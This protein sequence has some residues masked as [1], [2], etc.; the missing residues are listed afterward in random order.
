MLRWLCLATVLLAAAPPTLAQVVRQP[1]VLRRAP[2]LVPDAE[3]A[4]PF[5]AIKADAVAL[6]AAK[7]APAD[8]D[9]LLAY[10]ERRTLSDVD[11][12]AIQAVIDRLGAESFGDRLKAMD[13]AEKYGP[14]AVGP[15]RK[16]TA[17]DPTNVNAANFELAYRAG[18]VLKRLEKVPHAGIAIAAVRALA[19][20]PHP[21]TSRVL[22]GFLPQADDQATAEEIQRTLVVVASVGGKADA[23]L[24]ESLKDRSTLKR[25]YAATALIEGGDAKLRVRLPDAYPKVVEAARAE[26]DPDAKFVMTLALA[27]T[28]R[29]KEAVGA[30]L[31]MLPEL[32]RGRL[33]Q[34]EDLLLVLAGADAPKVAFGATKPAVVAAQAAWQAWWAKASPTLDLDKVTYAPRVQGKTLLVVMDP[35]NGSGYVAELGPDLK[36]RWR[37]TNLSSPHDA[38]VLPDGTVAVAE[39]NISSVSVRDTAGRLLTQKAITGNAA[40][41]IYGPPHQLQV[42]PGGDFVVVCRNVVVELKRD[43]PDQPVVFDRSNNHDIIAATRLPDGETA[44]LLL[45]ATDRDHLIVLD[46]A[47]KELPDRK[48]KTG[49]LPYQG[50]MVT[51]GEN[52]VLLTEQQKVVEYDLKE[53]KAVWSHAVMSARSVQRLPNGN[54]LMVEGNNSGEG[55]NRVI[56]VTPA[57]EEV[58]THRLPGGLMVVRAYRR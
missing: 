45:T 54:T 52:R 17:I 38:Q 18:E 41:R 21:R 51:S 46:K 56:E 44:V 22:L 40:R 32:A 49:L 1:L 26:A 36:E 57:G 25:V 28:A 42:L 58:W 31:A 4:A 14:A 35:R 9:G 47:G 6:A 55:S 16:A 8:A 30:I 24:V 11:A 23:F 7:I 43:K 53:K 50:H 2:V 29:D 19:K 34:A 20:V 13:D 12:N 3:A 39:N 48:V 33:W 37:M 27:V 15:L 5:D 10:F